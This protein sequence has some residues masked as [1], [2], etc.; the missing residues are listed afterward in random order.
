M[1]DTRPRHLG[2]LPQL[3]VALAVAGWAVASPWPV[4]AQ[5]RSLNLSFMGSNLFGSNQPFEI[6]DQQTDE[7]RKSNF[8]DNNLSPDPLDT[9]LNTFRY[10]SGP[11]LAAAAEP[12]K[13]A[14]K[15]EASGKGAGHE[16]LAAAATNPIANLIQ[17]QIQNIFIPTSWESSGYANQ[18]LIQPVI[19]INLHNKFFP[20]L[21]TRTTLP[22]V[23]TPNPDGPISGI[24]GTGDMVI[25]AT[26]INNQ[27]WG[28]IGVGPTFT[29]PTASDSRTGSE[30]WQAGPTLVLFVT[31]F[32]PWQFGA[33]VYTQHSFAGT[34][35]RS[36]VSELFYQP[37]LVRHF[38]KGWYAALP[39]VA[40]TTDFR[41]GGNT[42][43]FTGL[44]VGKV[45]TIKKQPLNVFLQ[46][47]GTPVHDG[48][49]GQFN[50]KLSVSF[51]FPVKK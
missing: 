10:K 41:T 11:V 50:I 15:A 3:M 36:T 19:P 9:P 47:W 6:Q 24:T 43:N 21:L 27:P 35:A 18:F 51:L 7:S 1:H 44:R 38:S 39:D 17:F 26:A 5:Q 32:H 12:Q 48:S 49:V 42:I 30:K 29:F 46:T 22:I 16:D 25:L 28:M 23:T 34:S 8:L 31:K 40:S 37:I 14:A 45:V 13:P 2:P 33:L 4:E 20:T